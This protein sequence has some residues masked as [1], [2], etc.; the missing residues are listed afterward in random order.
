M[1]DVV[2]VTAV[3]EEKLLVTP[4]RGHGLGARHDPADQVV[5]TTKLGRLVV[6]EDLEH[7]SVWLNQDELILEIVLVLVGPAVHIIRLEIDLEGPVS[8]LDF[9]TKLIEL[10][11]L[12][13]RGGTDM[14]GGFGNE[15]SPGLSKALV[16]GLLQDV[17]VAVLE[18]VE[19]R[20]SVEG[21]SGD[22]VSG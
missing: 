21:E 9:V 14:V 16:V 13:Q 1:L 20:L 4:Q 2:L 6:G 18:E 17:R 11:E 19:G 8:V 10:R 5:F 22:H 3:L 15:S 12:H 7:G